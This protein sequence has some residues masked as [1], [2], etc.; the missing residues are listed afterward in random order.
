MSDKL[1][2][3][4][5][6]KECRYRKEEEMMIK[7][8]DRIS[9]DAIWLTQKW[10]RKAVDL[11]NELD[12]TRADCARI[13]EERDKALEALKQTHKSI[14]EWLH[15]VWDGED[16]WNAVTGRLSQIIAELEK[17]K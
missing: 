8:Q 17:A 13:Q 10:N 1:L 4:M 2:D 16:G 6:E 3:E 9:K 14:G 11:Q 15:D 5:N 12:N 7:E